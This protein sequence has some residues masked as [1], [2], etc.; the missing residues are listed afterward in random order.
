[1]GANTRRSPAIV[2]LGATLLLVGC[3]TPTVQVTLD[4]P[5]PGVIATVRCVGP[6]VAG[7]TPL[8][9]DV[10]QISTDTGLEFCL[11]GHGDATPP[12]GEGLV[13]A[14]EF[15]V[16]NPGTA[17]VEL[18]ADVPVL[19]SPTYGPAAVVAPQG[20]VLPEQ[21]G[22]RSSVSA[23]VLYEYSADQRIGAQLRWADLVVEL[24][25]S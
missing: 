14:V 4:G 20:R 3:G 19:Q 22:P 15:T 18:P 23:R 1:M 2:V 24:E 21:L 6:A 8:P 11:V 25:G 10:T 16:Q 5:E 9:A 12:D 13:T 7:T 17:P